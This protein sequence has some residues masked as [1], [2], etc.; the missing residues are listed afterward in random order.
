MLFSQSSIVYRAVDEADTCEYYGN[1]KRRSILVLRF[2][3]PSL[4]LTF[5]TSLLALTAAF[6]AGM[7]HAQLHPPSDTD[8]IMKSKRHP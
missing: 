6:A 4:V 2:S 3:W 8:S 7:R 5:I 1:D